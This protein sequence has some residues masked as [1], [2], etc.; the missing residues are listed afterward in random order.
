MQNYHKKLAVNN[1][2]IIMIIYVCDDLRSHRGKSN[3]VLF[4]QLLNI[5][6]DYVYLISLLV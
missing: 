6:I 4:D 1:I 5:Q 2:Y 3:E